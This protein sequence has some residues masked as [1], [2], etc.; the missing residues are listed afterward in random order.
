MSMEVSRNP[1]PHVSGTPVISVVFAVAVFLASALLFLVEPMIAKMILPQLGGSPAV[2]NTALVFF[3]ATL[4]LGYAYAHASFNRLRP[5]R[6]ALS[7]V[8]LLLVPIAFLPIALPAGWNSPAQVGPLWVFALLAVSMGLPFFALSTMS[9][10]LQR[11]Y[12]NATQG[13]DP[14]FLYAVGNTGSL[15]GLLAYPIVVERTLTVAGQ[16]RVWTIGYVAFLVV[17]IGSAWLA[18]RHR[19]EASRPAPSEPPPPVVN[20]S[21]RTQV[22]WV[23]L[24]F[25]P[26]SLLL[27][28]TT[29]ITSEVGSIP[30]LWVL[31]LAVY[32]ITFIIAFARGNVPSAAVG[33]AILKLATIG[34][35]VTWALRLQRPLW[36]LVTLHLV[37][38]LGAGLTAHGRLYEDRPPVV[39]LTRF[40]LLISL[41]GVVGGLFNALLAPLLFVVPVEYPLVL[42]AALLLRKAGTDSRPLIARYGLALAAP[43]A[44]GVTAA[45]TASV[46]I[47]S[48]GAVAITL[49][50]P[51]ILLLAIRYPPAFALAFALLLIVRPPVTTDGLLVARTFFGLHRVTEAEGVR[52]L[53]NGLTIHGTQHLGEAAQEPT[54]YYHTSGPLG[55]VFRVFPDTRRVLVIGLGAG[56]I[57]AY[58]TAD[59]EFT[60][61]EIDPQ[62][63]EIATNPDLFTYLSDAPGSIR[64]ITNDG[65]LAAEQLEVGAYDLVIL[66]AF[67]ADA[68]P[69]HL[70][71]GEAAQTYETLLGPSGLI[72]FNIT[73]RHFDLEPA[74]GSLAQ[75]QGYGALTRAYESGLAPGATASQWA[76]LAPSAGTLEPLRSEPGW[77]DPTID[78]DFR[79]WTDD[80]SNL[81]SVLR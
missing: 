29:F 11:W 28:S 24:A 81:L 69:V 26:S 37:L 2:W 8:A 45:I 39:G 43:V 51:A 75:S 20:L 16:A 47:A 4:L 32:L 77:R 44:M 60:F 65:R 70:F 3:Q 79:L 56:G 6:Q 21:W 55:D 50:V 7:H 25:V 53:F 73:N 76:V 74:V 12:A 54:A 48:A 9:P 68:I 34:V 72:V 40:Y 1:Y 41:G 10:V 17:A 36:A 71:T 38:L 13:G 31:P 64:I 52:T 80:Y 27:G 15:V 58:A 23:A 78:P 57:A 22:R 59:T 49:A 14:Y 5:R 33:S 62:V 18:T 35:F 42:V 61:V 30:L 67:T 66:D 63:V 46:G 19:E